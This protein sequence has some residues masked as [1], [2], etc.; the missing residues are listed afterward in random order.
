MMKMMIQWIECFGR[1]YSKSWYE[2]QY[3]EDNE[4]DYSVLTVNLYFDEF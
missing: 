1:Y 3:I 4:I 2:P